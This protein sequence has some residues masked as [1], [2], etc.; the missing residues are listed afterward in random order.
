MGF[1]QPI[2]LRDQLAQ[3]ALA[4]KAL[5]QQNKK[6]RSV[7]KKTV[8]PM[9]QMIGQLQKHF[10]SVFPK[11]P[12]PKMP[13]KMGVSTDLLEQSALLG[14]NQEVLLD[15]IKIWCKGNRYWTCRVEE[16]GRVTNVNVS[17]V[18]TLKFRTQKNKSKIAPSSPAEQQSISS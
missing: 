16:A 17:Q 12:S 9:V 6:T 10:P 4:E 3:Q 14:I 2:S 7:S 11:S 8:D 15:A 1:E 5:N 13:L 18:R